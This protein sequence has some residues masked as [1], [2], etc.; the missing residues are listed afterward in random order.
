MYK[1][2]I[3][4]KFSEQIES[5]EELSK[6]VVEENFGEKSIYVVYSNKSLE[7]YL[8]GK[9]IDFVKYVIKDED[10]ENKWKDFLKEGWLTDNFFY[11][12]D[13]DKK[14]AN[15]IVITP[16]MAFGTGDHPTTKIAARLLE[17]IV[18]DKTVL[19][20]GSGSG[21]LSILASKCGAK[22]VF[23]CDNDFAT[24]YNLKENCLNN[25]V[26]NI[27]FWCGS[28]D[29]IKETVKYDVIVANIISSVLLSLMV[30][31]EKYSGDYIVLS[32]ILKGEV[33]SFKE[34]LPKNFVINKELEIDGWWGVRLKRCLQ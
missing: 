24:F 30:Y 32:G 9:N 11:T 33:D 19:E 6:L 28:I 29:C 8:K 17:E 31:F 27:S 7:N 2:V 1:Y 3:S 26:Y 15:S 21:I 13:K 5:D 23:A 25:N 20:V 12:F 10:W 4:N 22:K 34:M 16:A 18:S 14:S